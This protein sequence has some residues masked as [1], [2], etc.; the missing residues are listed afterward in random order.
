MLFVVCANIVKIRFVP[1]NPFDD[2]RNSSLVG[3]VSWIEVAPIHWPWLIIIH[4]TFT[5]LFSLCVFVCLVPFV[6]SAVDSYGHAMVAQCTGHSAHCTQCNSHSTWA[7]SRTQNQKENMKCTTAIYNAVMHDDVSNKYLMQYWNRRRSKAW[8]LAAW[9]LCRW[10][11]E[12]SSAESSVL[13]VESRSECASHVQNQFPGWM[14][15]KWECSKSQ[16][17]CGWSH[18]VRWCIAVSLLNRK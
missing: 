6:I 16:S 7:F 13:S 11:V 5:M 4:S 10:S 2:T 8:I 18:G 14:I 3:S 17:A 12:E 1:W 15:T 9:M